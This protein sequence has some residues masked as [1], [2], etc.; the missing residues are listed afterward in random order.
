MSGILQLVDPHGNVHTVPRMQLRTFCISRKLHASN[1]EKHV[2]DPGSDQKNDGWR[3]VERLKWLRHLG[4]APLLLP[5]LGTIDTFS[6][7]CISASDARSSLKS[8]ECIQKL[9]AG[10][11]PGGYKGGKPYGK[12]ER[13]PAPADA[14]LI[15]SERRWV[16]APQV[17]Q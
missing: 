8:R 6:A 3:L 15:L 13:I 4:D 7:T 1:M 16:G 14:L 11:P 17:L 12:W 10:E 9:L 5:A 2:L